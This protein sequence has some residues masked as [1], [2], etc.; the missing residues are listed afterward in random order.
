MGAGSSGRRR[1]RAA[2]L[3][4][5]GALY[6]LSIPWYRSSGE[7]PSIVF[8][9]PDWVAVALGCYALAAVLN[10]LAWLGTDVRDA[11]DEDERP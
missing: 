6:A 1:L 7:T 10:A 8:G 11:P 4:A 9:L 5:I 2:L 3:V